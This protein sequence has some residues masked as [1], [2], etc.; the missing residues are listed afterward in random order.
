M[1][2]CHRRSEF[3][4]YFLAVNSDILKSILVILFFLSFHS[5]KQFEEWL[6]SS[7]DLQRRRR[8][9][10]PLENVFTEKKNNDWIK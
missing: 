2:S 7:N 3:A 8:I 10:L 1:C 5:L 4:I 9:L 6:N